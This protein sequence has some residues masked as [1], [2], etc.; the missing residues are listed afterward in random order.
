M[1]GPYGITATGFVAKPL[2]DIRSEL[3]ASFRTTFGN[4]IDLTPDSVFSQLI[5]IFSDRLADLWQ[6]SQVLYSNAFPDG[7]S[8]AALDSICS[9]TGVARLPATKTTVQCTFTG[10]PSTVIPIGSRAQVTGGGAVFESTSA[11]T[12]GAGGTVSALLTAIETGPKPA[13]AGT[14]TVIV[15]PVA[16]W[17]AVT[18]PLDQ[19]TLGRDLETDAALRLRRELSVKA[20]GSG[21]REAIRAAIAAIAGVTSVRVFENQTNVTDASGIPANSFESVVLGGVDA[22]IAQTIYD[23]KPIGVGTHGNTSAAA[24]DPS[25]TGHI[26]NFSRPVTLLG[27]VTVS[28]RARA[29]APADLAAR[30][31]SAIAAYGDL[32]ISVGDLLIAAALVP[33]VFAAD[34]TIIDVPSV[35]IGT[36]PSP[37]SSVTVTPT[38]RQ[39]IDLDTS[40][41]VVNLTIV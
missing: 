26:V 40:R 6:A 11:I 30:V 8:G 18:N 36:A 24:F 41:V 13:P 17:S 29:G 23:R 12:I 35:F 25:G 10:T 31:R 34:G 2:A 32:R 3:E 38:T 15:T 1:P 37:S 16:G 21:S 28:I 33:S 22:S 9:I 27:Y 14:L 19:A 39:I 7:A 20:L 5:G 4:G